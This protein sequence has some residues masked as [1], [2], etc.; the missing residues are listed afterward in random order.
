MGERPGKMLSTLTVAEKPRSKPAGCVGI[1]FQLFDWNRRFARKKLFSNRFLLGARPKKAS[2]KFGDDKLPMAKLLLIADENRGGFPD[3]KKSAVDGSSSKVAENMR[4]SVRFPGAIGRLMGL[5]TMPTRGFSEPASLEP[6]KLQTQR[7]TSDSLYDDQCPISGKKLVECRPQKLQKTG[8]FER[9]PV[10]KSK[11]EPFQF[12]SAVS[13]SRRQHQK[14]ITPV[15]SS[16]ILHGRNAVRLME[17][18]TKILEPGL[19]A[20]SRTRC[21]LP[22]STKPQLACAEKA[23]RETGYMS[24]LNDDFECLRD[25]F[26]IDDQES[27]AFSSS[28]SDA[29]ISHNGGYS[30]K[31]SCSWFPPEEDS[32]IARNLQ[33]GRSDVQK[34]EEKLKPNVKRIAESVEIMGTGRPFDQKEHKPDV[35]DKKGNSQK[36]GRTNVKA[37]LS[38]DLLPLNSRKQNQ[39]FCSKYRTY[40]HANK[41]SRRCSSCEASK[42]SAAFTRNLSSLARSGSCAK[43]VKNKYYSIDKR[44]DPLSKANVLHCRKRP[45]ECASQAGIMGS[46]VHPNGRKG[47]LSNTGS[48]SNASKDHPLAPTSL[49]TQRPKHTCYQHGFPVHVGYIDTN[50]SDEN[51]VSFTFTSSVKP[52]LPVSP[53]QQG[54]KNSQA[55]FICAASKSTNDHCSKSR[56]SFQQK[57]RCSNVNTKKLTSQESKE[58]QGDSLSALLEKKLKELTC[59][60]GIELSRLLPETCSM[61]HSEAPLESPTAFL[62]LQDLTSALTAKRSASEELQR[63]TSL[64]YP[65]GDSMHVG[66]L[67]ETECSSTSD[68]M[69]E[70]QSPQEVA[71]GF[72]GNRK[73]FAGSPCENRNDHESSIRSDGKTKFSRFPF[74]NDCAHPSPVSILDASFSNESCVSSESNDGCG[75]THLRLSFTDC[76]PRRLQ[77]YDADMELVDSATSWNSSNIGRGRKDIDCRQICIADEE[78]FGILSE[79]TSASSEEME[80]FYVM[81]VLSSIQLTF[82][83]IALF[84]ADPPQFSDPLLFQKLETMVYKHSKCKYSTVFMRADGC[85]IRRFVFDCVMENLALKIGRYSRSI[86]RA[87]GKLSLS[88]SQER[89][90]KEVYEEVSKHRNLAGRV[91]DDIVEWD[92]NSPLGKWT[93]FEI[94][95]FETTLEIEKYILQTMI[96]EFALDLLPCRFSSL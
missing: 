7:K 74:P 76:S 38:P 71:Q 65:D 22:C 34:N 36:H 68:G 43:E 70:A 92:M 16:G 80:F 89:L 49:R 94:E 10:T 25:F 13:R 26:I 11:K 85:H 19:L 55:E 17:A 56:N 54:G 30:E 48:R 23:D 62:V 42:E 69:I 4:T 77:Q 24:S 87:L 37:S 86:Y 61:R 27:I 29:N 88:L 63:A 32:G 46:A 39:I 72:V 9:R 52:P 95:A 64:G 15:E 82:E 5:E 53:N 28:Y 8:I 66:Y 84:G 41:N 78:S 2:K 33:S 58:L 91:L 45:V 21:A 50:G 60:D 73:P 12:K 83:N 51:T 75:A 44:D 35:P 18:A 20:S 96:A 79:V 40:E 6:Q 1:F 3:T 81:K 67:A 47:K 31:K 93:D 90:R 14:L 57:K 59:S